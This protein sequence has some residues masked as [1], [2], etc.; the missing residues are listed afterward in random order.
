MGEARSH[1][2]HNILTD[3]VYM[4]QTSLFLRAIH[5]KGHFYSIIIIII[6]FYL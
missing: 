6:I 1:Y 5:L 4:Q 2:K 3:N